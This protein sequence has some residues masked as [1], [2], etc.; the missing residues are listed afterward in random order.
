[1][2]VGFSP[3]LVC[4]SFSLW[5]F[6]MQMQLVVTAGPEK[7]RT[8]SLVDG[9]TLIIGRGQASDTKLDDPHMSRVHC[10]VQVDGGKATL[11]DSGSAGGTLIDG[12]PVEKHELK[13]GELVRA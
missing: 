9:K 5:S 8:F 6:L 2:L 3:V 4:I 13:P 10:L 12:E 7:G 1:M 11:I